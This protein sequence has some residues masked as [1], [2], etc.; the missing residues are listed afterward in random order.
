MRVAR[1]DG[2]EA[3]I[4]MTVRFPGASAAEEAEWQALAVRHVGA[5]GWIQRE[6]D[7]ELDLVGPVAAGI[8]RR[9]G[10]PYPYNLH[11]L[12]P[13]MEEARGGTLVTGLGGDQAL[14]PAGR[15][16]DTLARRRRPRPRD[17]LRI[18]AGL[19]PASVRRA[20]IRRG[21]PDLTFPWLTAAANAELTRRWVHESARQPF[22]WDSAL[23]HFWQ[24]R[25]MQTTLRQIAGLAADIGAQ[26]SHPLADPDFIAA[27]A[28]DGGRTGFT[29]RTAAMK[30]LFGADL[31]PDLVGRGSKASFDDALWNNYTRAFVDGLD[32]SR[33]RRALERLELRDIVDA[34]K[35]AEHWSEPSA[36]ANSFLLLQATWLA[37]DGN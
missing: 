23:R 3:P 28:H 1:T 24:S 15:E 18:A 10:L 37:L 35:L 4:P 34:R 32:E 26:V 8:M 33:L 25:F 14:R 5:P 17:P 29:S 19:A 16:L 36:L 21:E 7:D 11:L 22:W 31:P 27:L 12:A 6:F 2:L 9:H 13:M 30:A 20:R